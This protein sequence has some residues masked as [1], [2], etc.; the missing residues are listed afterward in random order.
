[1]ALPVEI[2]LPL[3][4]NLACSSSLTSFTGCF[5]G[6]LA[7][8]LAGLAEAAAFDGERLLHET[9]D[10]PA[11]PANPGERLPAACSSTPTSV[12]GCLVSLLAG[13]AEATADP[14]NPG[15]RPPAAFT[16]GSGGSVLTIFGVTGFSTVTSEV[17]LTGLLTLTS[18]TSRVLGGSGDCCST[19]GFGETRL[20]W[21]SSFVAAP[22]P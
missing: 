17:C 11:D 9:S 14:A 16:S 20:F 12:T 6:L 4:S 7:G 2:D 10:N 5:V 19:G 21:P 18:L 1:M 3:G 8:L 13:L 22:G 15:D